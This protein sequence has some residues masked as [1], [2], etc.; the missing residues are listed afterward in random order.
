MTFK[1]W[2]TTVVV[3][4]LGFMMRFWIPMTEVFVT[5][6]SFTITK[7]WKS[8]GLPTDLCHS[9]DMKVVLPNFAKDHCFWTLWTLNYADC[10]SFACIHYFHM[11]HNQAKQFKKILILN[12]GKTWSNCNRCGRGPIICLSPSV[13]DAFPSGSTQLIFIIFCRRFFHIY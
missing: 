7:K 3:S 6:N 9:N 5:M 12:F 10:I 11:A 13:C 1:C 4:D 2:G 8:I